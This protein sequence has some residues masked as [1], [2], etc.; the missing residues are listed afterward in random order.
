MKRYYDGDR[1]LEDVSQA[2]E[3][4]LRKH[5]VELY[6]LLGVTTVLEIIASPMKMHISGIA[7]HEM[8]MR[9][10]EAYFASTIPRRVALLQSPHSETVNPMMESISVALSRAKEPVAD[11]D[12]FPAAMRVFLKKPRLSAKTIE[13][14]HASYFPAFVSAREYL[15]EGKIISQ[16]EAGDA[17]R[18]NELWEMV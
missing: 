11:A 16:T 12:L 10:V 17:W 1:I 2:L 8:G 18:L 13:D 14:E 6:S 3:E 15:T 5:S 4:A 9:G 7:G